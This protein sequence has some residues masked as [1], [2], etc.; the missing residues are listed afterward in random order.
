M[1]DQ[2]DATDISPNQDGGVLK[3]IVQE[4]TGDELPPQGCKVKVHY[5]GT[6]TDG[7]K[8][9]SSRDRNE[10]FQF[11]LGKGSVIKAWDLGVATMKKG[12]R[13]ILTC[14][15]EYAYGENGSPPTIP[16]NATLLFDVEVIS[17]EGEDLSPK[18]NLG[19]YLVSSLACSS[20]FTGKI[21]SNRR[22]RI[23]E[24]RA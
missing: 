11:D 13:A 16:P 8:F 6:L 7:T 12:E 15:P 14:A 9:D 5:T 3:K 22:D 19:A 1:A 4:G 18:F 23:G 24:C 21:C 10:P 20:Y 2:T 17:W